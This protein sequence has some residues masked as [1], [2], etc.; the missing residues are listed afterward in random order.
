MSDIC[1]SR[2]ASSKIPPKV[3]E[4]LGEGIDSLLYV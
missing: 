4:L 1:S 3:G 2:L